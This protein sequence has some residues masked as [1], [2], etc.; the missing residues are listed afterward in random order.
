MN[1]LTHFL[2]AANLLLLIFPSHSP[3]AASSTVLSLKLIFLFAFIFG[4]MVDSDVFWRMGVMKDKS[5]IT[6]TWLQEPFGLIVVGGSIA[7]ILQYVYGSPFALLVLVP[8]A[9]HVILDYIAT[10]DVRPFDPFSKKVFHAGFINTSWP[11]AKSNSVKQRKNLTPR[12][13][14]VFASE[15]YFTAA[16]AIVFLGLIWMHG[17]Y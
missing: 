13:F 9:S 11:K 12:T 16:N 14:F 7:A 6:R 3:A 17:M 5:P 8:Y 1:S 4:V 2:F 15:N 10:H